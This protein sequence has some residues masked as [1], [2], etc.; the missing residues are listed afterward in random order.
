MSAYL[1]YITLR[2]LRELGLWIC[3]YIIAVEV[4]KYLV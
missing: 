1:R 3:S 4:S 2:F